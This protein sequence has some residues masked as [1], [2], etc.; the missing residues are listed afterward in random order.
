M[1]LYV[2]KFVGMMSG[3]AVGVSQLEKKHT[4]VASM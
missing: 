4:R 3:L 2:W 1:E